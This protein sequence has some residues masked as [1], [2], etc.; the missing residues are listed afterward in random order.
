[1]PYERQKKNRP[2]ASLIKWYLD[3]K[4]GK[5]TDARNEIQKRFDYLDWRVQKQILLAFLQA[6]KSDREWAY[7]K[8]YRLWDDCFIEPLE[9]LWEQYHENLCAWSVIEHFPIEYVK[10]NMAMLE[11][12]NGY[13]HLCLRL[14]E[15]PS[16]IIDRSRLSGK[17]YLLVMLHTHREVAEEE[18]RDIF[19][20]YL[21]KF[22]LTDP[23]NLYMIHHK[24]RGFPFGVEDIRFMNSVLWLFHLL[25][26]EQLRESIRKWDNEV[27]QAIGQSEEMKSL[28]SEAIDDDEYNKKR[29]AIGLDYLYRALDGKYKQPTDNFPIVRQSRKETAAVLEEMKADNPAVEQLISSFSLTDAAHNF[30]Y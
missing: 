14:A 1:M 21:H 16:Y 6:C 13:Y 29:L 19:F 30:I 22:C 26:L 23:E 15:D 18:A 20:N 10:E 4:S 28:T 27:M 25:G 5:V 17:E 2:I 8:V 9:A 3:K 24:L 7:M 11:E 12:A